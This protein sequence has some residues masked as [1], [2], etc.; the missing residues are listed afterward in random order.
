MKNKTAQRQEVWLHRWN[1]GS[2]S[3]TPPAWAALNKRLKLHRRAAALHIPW[4]FI[5]LAR[6][7]G[8][9][10][11]CVCVCVRISMS[12]SLWDCDC[13]CIVICTYFS[14]RVKTTQVV[15]HIFQNKELK[16]SKV[17]SK[18]HMQHFLTACTCRKNWE[19]RGAA[20][21]RDDKICESIKAPNVFTSR[22]HVCV[23]V[24]AE[25]R[26][27][28]LYVTPYSLEVQINFWE[29]I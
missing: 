20:S 25:S 5:C 8:C 15:D 27:A 17:L 10:C 21:D 7:R 2:G 9:V 23:I 13:V 24:C 28:P 19:L 1:S 22:L 18:I 29:S 3:F 16:D 4:D 6:W 14:A 12:E 26:T 11:V